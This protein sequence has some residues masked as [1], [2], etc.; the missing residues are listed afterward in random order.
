MKI[1]ESLIWRLI[2]LLRVVNSFYFS[3]HQI[4]D[5]VLQIVKICCSCIIILIG[6]LISDILL[7]SLLALAEK[8]CEK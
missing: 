3:A 5:H 4:G 2:F 1:L 6:A 7:W 8:P